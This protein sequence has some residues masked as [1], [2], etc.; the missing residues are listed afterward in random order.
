MDTDKPTRFFYQIF[1]A[2]LPRLGPGD[3]ASTK[4]ALDTL[5]A[6][7]SHG[8]DGPVA[9]PLRILD[10]GCGNGTQ[11]LCLARHAD[12]SIL[13]VDNHRPYLDELQ[14]RAATAG[15]SDKIHVALREMQ[16]LTKDDGPFDLIW[17]EGALFV[18]GFREGLAACH[19]LLAPGGGLAVSELAWL[20]P[21]PPDECRRFW[22]DAYPAMT[23]IA[24]NRATIE[25]CGYEVL[26][27]FIQPES[28]WWQPYYH[29][30]EERLAVMRE[31]HPADAE[32]QFLVDSIQK[33]IDC[34]R[35]YA[36]FCG[37]VFYLMRP[38]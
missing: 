4:R 5:L 35:K 25:D 24:E 37:N 2:S 13:A 19:G 11:T 36:A 1:D 27:H 38:R 32:K 30:L 3:E 26:D 15:V 20:R 18:M 34:Y 29:P 6:A 28:A 23:G 7:M 33:E 10:L 17:S 8:P 21:D 31:W 9:G 12:G 16:T 14:R 22:S